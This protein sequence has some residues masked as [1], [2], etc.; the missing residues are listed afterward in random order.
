[1]TA[2]RC[3]FTLGGFFGAVHTSDVNQFI[4]RNAAV[5]RTAQD[6]QTALEFLGGT[7]AGATAINETFA[8]TTNEGAGLVALGII[9][10]SDSAGAI[11]EGT[12][13]ELISSGLVTSTAGIRYAIVGV[14]TAVSGATTS[15]QIGGTWTGAAAASMSA[16]QYRIDDLSEGGGADLALVE[17]TRASGAA[18]ALAI[19][20]AVDATQATRSATAQALDLSVTVT[21]GA[22]GIDRAGAVHGRARGGCAHARCPQRHGTGFHANRARCGR[23][24][25]RNPLCDGTGRP[26]GRDGASKPCGALGDGTGHA[27]C[28]EPEYGRCGALG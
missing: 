13:D 28:R 6:D 17:S 27:G 3:G 5:T 24:Y 9:A 1:M 20:E 26:S 18:Q 21:L 25:A 22:A 2:A 7:V 16:D 23:P 4:N 15:G 19:S 8:E 14:Q 10:A 11:T 12:G